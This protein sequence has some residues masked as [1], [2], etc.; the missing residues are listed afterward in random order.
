[1]NIDK[2]LGFKK[3][4]FSKR[5]SEQELDFIHKIFYEP[6]YYKTL[7]ND[8]SNGD[9]SF[10]IG[11]RGHGKTAVINKLFDDLVVQDDLFIIKIDRFDSIP[12]KRNESAFL[13][14]ILKEAVT[15][16]GIVLTKNRFLVSKLSRIEKQKLAFLIQHF[17]RTI[18]NDEYSQVYNNVKKIRI[19]NFF[20]RLY[21]SFFLKTAN[22][23]TSAVVGITSNIIS[24]SL[25]LNQIEPPPTYREYLGPISLT[26]F[27]KIDIDS[28]EISK[29]NLKHILDD[30]LSILEALDFKT[31]VVLF[32][33]IDEY[34]E[35]NQDIS[36]IGLFTREI[37]SD[38]ELLMNSKLAIGFSLW[39]EL[40]S[41]LG[42]I[43]RFDKFDSVDVS[44]QPRDL[45]PL[46]NKRIAHFSINV[47]KKLSDLIDFQGDIDE[48]I[49]LS[50]RSPRDLITLLGE[51]Y[52][53][54]ANSNPNA[55]KFESGAISKGMINFCTNYDYDSLYPSKTGKNKDIKS[56]INRILAI[57]LTRFTLRNLSD[58]FNQPAS[59]SEGQI[60]KMIQ[61][62]LIN[63]E[64]ILSNTNAKFF[65]IID[66]KVSYLIRRAINRI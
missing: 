54:Q 29:E 53:E 52:K 31:L 9:S 26:D 35:L 30:L 40:K 51:I 1:M 13:K 2:N 65:E 58:T 41:E 39:S 23:I 14:I 38:T 50:R 44:W 48:I 24:Q 22:S 49:N 47:K 60:K 43:V 61:Y 16:L 36:K 33:K 63:E 46:I 56:M 34:Q 42:G 25:G 28:L 4:P 11:Q 64:E 6:N 20:V 3:N 8:L 45:E 10:I 15:K 59:Q 57:K 12:V 19:K 32:D 21:N 62:E 5:S 55:Q 7:L 18:N 37:L 27:S 66:P 17:F